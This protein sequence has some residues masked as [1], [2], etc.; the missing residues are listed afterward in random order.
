[1][2]GGVL[3][4]IDNLMDA[5][6]TVLWFIMLLSF[7][8]W[9]LIIERFFYMRYTYPECRRRWIDAWKKTTGKHSWRGHSIRAYYIAQAKIELGKTVPIIKS[10]IALC[11]L[12]GLL[13]TVT[14]MIETFDVMAV[15]GTGNARAMASGV[16]EATVTTMA[17]MVVAISCL[18]F[19]KR[20]EDRVDEEARHL[21]D[22][23][24]YE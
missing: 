1:M 22:L 4:F 16:S 11:P 17:G 7:L 24:T 10:L 20:I 15:I 12:L 18:Y 8:L 23:L 2:D 19:S 5:G 6:G 13:G 9:T 3:F 21:A 14:G